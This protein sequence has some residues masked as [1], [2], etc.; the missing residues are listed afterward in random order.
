M[1]L[2]TVMAF[3]TFDPLHLGHLRYFQAAK[4]HGTRLVVVVA[5][6]TTV[7][8]T[9]GMLPRFA[10][11]DRLEMVKALR[12]VDLAV[13]GGKGDKLAVIRKFR[14]SVVVLGYDQRVDEGCLEEK[15]REAG[16]KARVVR[17]AKPY[18]PLWHK[19]SAIKRAG[20]G[21]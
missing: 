17:V 5:R 18:A 9:K 4:K 2:K 8:K 11:R 1:R 20:F 21:D 7:R 19:S 10:E 16:L 13:L 3:G 15:L 6:D 12:I 14:P